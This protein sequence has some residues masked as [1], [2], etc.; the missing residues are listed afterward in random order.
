[1]V[2]LEENRNFYSTSSKGRL[3]EE[4]FSKFLRYKGFTV[5]DRRLDDVYMKKDID[6]EVKN[7][8]K[9][10]YSVEVKGDTRMAKTQ[11]IFVEES[12]MRQ[13]GRRNGWLYYCEADYL[14]F[15]DLNN[16]IFYLIKWPELKERILRGF[17]PLSSFNNKIDK[18]E[19]YGYKVPVR[20][21]FK[22]NLLQCVDRIYFGGRS[23]EN[24]A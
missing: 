10:L 21:L 7:G 23:N 2:L 16:Y 1:M 24:C 13:S 5:V 14:C 3:A 4:L 15:M 6:F 8:S 11:N 20:D 12:M 9:F 18:C 17:W 19:G 22:M